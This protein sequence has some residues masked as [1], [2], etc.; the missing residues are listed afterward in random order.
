MYEIVNRI[1]LAYGL[2]EMFPE[3]INV[4]NNEKSVWFYSNST[5]LK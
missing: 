1:F 5:H 4:Q 3:K 2:D